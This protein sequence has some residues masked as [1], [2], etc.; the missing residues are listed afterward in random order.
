MDWEDL[1]VP[2]DWDTR[3][4]LPREEVKNN[5]EQEQQHREEVEGDMGTHSE[6]EEEERQL[7]AFPG[8]FLRCQQG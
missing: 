3:M 4:G 6:L 5:G 1:G 7:F 8:G 2:Q